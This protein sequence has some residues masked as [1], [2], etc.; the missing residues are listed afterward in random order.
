VAGV[1]DALSAHSL[2]LDPEFL[3]ER[4][5]AMAE[6]RAAM[7]ALLNA[8]MRPTAVICGN[9]VLAIG[10]LAACRTRGLG[11]PDDLSIAGFD[12]VETASYVVPSLTTIRVR[13]D[14]IGR[15]AADYLLG[16]LRNES[17]L[18]GI[19]VGVELVVR[20]ST[21]PPPELRTIVPGSTN[22]KARLERSRAQSGFQTVSPPRTICSS[23]PGSSRSVICAR[24]RREGS[25][26]W[27]EDSRS[28]RCPKIAA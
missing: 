9:D 18:D 8:P 1:Q 24:Q 21:K 27:I 6:G 22:L 11:V 26:A 7:A 15:R 20:D 13:A 16:R 5:Y 12:D 3:L 28:S 19:D 4:S 10:A 2:T 17:L 23:A 25:R 14:E